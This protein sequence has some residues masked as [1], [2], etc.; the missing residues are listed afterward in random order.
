[1]TDSELHLH[2]GKRLR[3]RRKLM[4]LTQQEL[5]ASVGVGFQ[6]I[7]KYECAANTLSATRLWRLAGRLGV[8]VE[9]FFE[10]VPARAPA[11]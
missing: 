8:G 11:A 7:Q 9:Y 3:S 6:Q 1:M 2:L 10:G 5:A 4:G